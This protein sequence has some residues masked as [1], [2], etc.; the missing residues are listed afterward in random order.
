M[1]DN[2]VT[3]HWFQLVDFGGGANVTKYINGPAGK[4]GTLIDYGVEDVTEAFAAGTA[5]PQMAVGVSGNT[6]AHGEEF[7]LGALAIASGGGS[8][9]KSYSPHSAEFAAVMVN[10]SLPADTT[11]HVT[12][13]AGTGSGLTGQALPYV[14]I[15][16]EK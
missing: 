16:W 13:I 15:A 10:P 5:L 9:K 4:K 2:P 12:C 11:I 3:R 6:D 1:Y 14:D 8:V 7:S